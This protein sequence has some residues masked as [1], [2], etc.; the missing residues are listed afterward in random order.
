MELIYAESIGLEQL[1]SLVSSSRIGRSDTAAENKAGGIVAQK[2]DKARAACNVTATAC[3]GLAEGAHEDI[4]V[5]RVSSEIARNASAALADSAEG[6]SLVHHKQSTVLL[7][8]PDE[9]GKVAD[10]AVHRVNTFGDN[11]NAPVL[12]LNPF[13][14]TLEVFHI[15]VLEVHSLCAGEYTALNAAVM[16]KCIVED[17]VIGTDKVADDIDISAV[18]ADEYDRI[19]SSEHTCDLLFE[20]FVKLYLTCEK[21]AARN[22]GAVAVDSGFYEFSYPLVA[23]KTEVIVGGEVDLF[24]TL[25]GDPSAGDTVVLLEVGNSAVPLLIALVKGDYFGKIIY[26]SLSDVSYQFSQLLIL[27]SVTI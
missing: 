6:M 13:E 10:I 18:A 26:I 3:R 22:G 17:K 19:I 27:K 12:V 16:C 4:N 14:Y 8:Q 25:N 11:E 9:F 20:E 23:V 7:L 24:L 5:L 15:V 21:A 1:D 2:S